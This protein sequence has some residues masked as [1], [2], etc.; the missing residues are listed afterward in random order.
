MAK[1]R[2]KIDLMYFMKNDAKDLNK[3]SK[4]L[5]YFKKTILHICDIM[6]K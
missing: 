2:G 6:P 5:F 4:N 1:A 3:N